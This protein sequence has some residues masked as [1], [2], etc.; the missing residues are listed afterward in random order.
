MEPWF[1]EGMLRIRYIPDCSHWV[2]QEQPDLV[3]EYLLEF[4]G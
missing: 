1:G 4:F 3:N 2:Q